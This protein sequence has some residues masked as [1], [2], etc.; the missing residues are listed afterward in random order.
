MKTLCSRFVSAG[1]LRRQGLL[2]VLSAVRPRPLSTTA[3]DAQAPLPPPPSQRQAV[4]ALQDIEKFDMGHQEAH[5]AA[6]DGEEELFEDPRVKILD[7]ALR[8]VHRDG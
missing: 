5:G 8:H 3:P 1:G 7:A 6:D 2:P 4:Q